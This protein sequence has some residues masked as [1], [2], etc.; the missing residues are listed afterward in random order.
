[1][2]YGL[3]QLIEMVQESPPQYVVK[4]LMNHRLI[5]LLSQR[6]NLNMQDRR[7]N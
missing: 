6:E 7:S 1:M 4:L 3:T 2:S 5:Q